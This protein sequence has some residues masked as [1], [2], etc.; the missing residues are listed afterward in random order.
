MNLTRTPARLARWSSRGSLYIRRRLL[1]S[2]AALLDSCFSRFGSCFM[3]P[4]EIK[5]TVE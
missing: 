1:T 2:V 4:S 3:K 5:A